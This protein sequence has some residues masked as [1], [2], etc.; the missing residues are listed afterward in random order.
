[1]VAS[2]DQFFLPSGIGDC[3]NGRYLNDKYLEMTI[4]QSANNLKWQ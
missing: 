4:I 1:M 2:D 3:V